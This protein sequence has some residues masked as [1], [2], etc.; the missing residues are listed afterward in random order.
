VLSIAGYTL[1]KAIVKVILDMPYLRV[2]EIARYLQ[3]PQYGGQKHKAHDV[4]HELKRM[5][6]LGPRERFE[7]VMNYLGSR[8][9]LSL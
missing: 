9:D 7:F 6:L 1:G 2:K 3:L 8:R 4:K 5:E